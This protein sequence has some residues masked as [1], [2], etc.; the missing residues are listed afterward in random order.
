M[1]TENLDETMP[2]PVGDETQQT[3]PPG[4]TA[5]TVVTPVPEEPKKKRGGSWV[6]WGLLAILVLGIF[7][8]V[9]GYLGYQ[10]GIN[11][12]TSFES[13]QVALA[14]QEQYD[15]GVEDLAAGRY[16][17]ARQRF[18]YV[19][20]NDPNFPGATD[21]MAE[22]LLILNATATPTPAPP[23]P[24]PTEIPV[25]P[26]PD[27]RGE[28]ELF[29]HAQNL[30][31]EKQWTEAIEALETLRKKNPEYKAIDVDG[32]FFVSF[33]NR[34]AQNIG[35][36][37][38]EGGIYD[39]TLAEQFGVLDTEANG[40][41]TWAR[42][43]ITGASFWGVDWSQAAYYFGQV[44]PQ[45]PNMHDGTGWTASQRYVEAIAGYAQWF[46]SQGKWCDAEAKYHEAWE[47][48]GN[49]EYKKAR[50][51]ASDKCN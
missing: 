9:G 49:Q 24:V 51:I 32:L 50:D 20:Q 15:L 25:T 43:Y 7:V 35:A 33:R 29:V 4:D 21:R 41:R 17:V 23:T 18:D 45:Y 22:V 10:Q 44:A 3:I 19:I 1:D 16:Y 46:E 26:T 47:I 8:I 34:G 42:Y 48:S 40:Y 28:E 37:N 30:I 12:R 31:A 38:L 2:T 39:L 36:G 11:E 14:V 27:L 6:L 13:E 5:P